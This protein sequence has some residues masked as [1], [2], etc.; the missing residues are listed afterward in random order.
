MGTLPKPISSQEKREA[1]DR[2]LQSQ[3]FARSDQLKKFLRYVCDMEMA[4]RAEEISEY[5]IAVEA[6]GRRSDYSPGG[7]STVRG[8]AHDLRLKLQQFYH[9]ECSNE[10][11]RITLQKGSYIPL[12]VAADAER[13]PA[14]IPEPVGAP[15]ATRSA[16]RRL[17]VV[18]VVA[19]LLATA[20]LVAVLFMLVRGRYSDP[21]VKEFWGPL[22][23]KDGGL[24]LCLGNPTSFVFKRFRE[25]PRG[26]AYRPAPP[27]IAQWMSGV[28]S[29]EGGSI[30][31]LFRVESPTFGDSA[32][33][34]VAA[35]TLSAAGV[36]FQLLAEASVRP[37]VLR[38]R[39]VLLIGAPSYS[40]Y[41]AR[42]LR[43]TPFTIRFDTATSE[44][45]IS[46]APRESNPKRV[47]TAKRDETGALAVAYG[48]ITV[49][50]S[51]TAV[52]DGPRTAIFSGITGA[53]AQAAMEFFSSNAGLGLLLARF[54]RDGIKRVP[55]SYQVVVRCT[56][57]HGLLMNW[58]FAAYQV[59]ERPP[60]LD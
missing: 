56:V 9:L 35:R 25:P 38:A 49:F 46:D 2:L 13:G 27:E 48:L 33:A 58:D 34:V 31:Y 29:L 4:G 15:A 36:P 54:Q 42:A 8:R 3:T 55:P 18:P 12:F 41:S 22:L 6:L 17:P 52:A 47:F 28:T 26:G 16:R 21:V 30:P 7:D 20:I 57:D 60:M 53:G 19:L 14:E 45:V 44:E 39:N 50:P 40:T 1:L 43:S 23:H 32:A 59:I 51:G 5:S 37:A 24:L 11:I 10:R